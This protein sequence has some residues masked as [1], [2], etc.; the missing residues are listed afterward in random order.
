MATE[1][2]LVL[3]GAVAGFGVPAGLVWLAEDL[4]PRVLHRGLPRW[5]VGLVVLFSLAALIPAAALLPYWFE[6]GFLIGLVI[7]LLVW[8]WELVRPQSHSDGQP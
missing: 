8:I 5:L 6:T 3:T 1:I 2:L 4:P 7:A